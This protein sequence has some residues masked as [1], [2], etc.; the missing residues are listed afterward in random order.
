MNEFIKTLFLY[1]TCLNCLWTIILKMRSFV[2][3]AGANKRQIY[4]TRVNDS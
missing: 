1:E 3:F 2:E 4:L